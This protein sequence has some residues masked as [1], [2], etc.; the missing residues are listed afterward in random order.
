MGPAHENEDHSPL[1]EESPAIT[2][3][4]TKLQPIEIVLACRY[5]HDMPLDGF[6]TF[7]H[8]AD[9]LERQL[10]NL[11][12]I[13]LAFART[14]YGAFAMSTHPADRLNVGL[15]LRHLTLVDHDAGF[16]LWRQLVRDEHPTVRR[17]V[18]RPIH[19]HLTSTARSA[20]QGL[21]EEGL[22]L[23]DGHQLRDAFLGA[24]Y[25]DG[26]HAIGQTAI[27][28]ALDEATRS[29]VSIAHL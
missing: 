21:T 28:E 24:Q 13:D 23:A 6:P 3:N 22:T 26:C 27:A 14:V 18:Y 10:E 25:P 11:P 9:E 5:L 16:S 2:L 19:K 17:D 4:L 1:A 12:K 7:D 8:L 29:F 20:E 15:M